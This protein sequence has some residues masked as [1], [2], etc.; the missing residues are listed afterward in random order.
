MAHGGQELGFRL[1]GLLGFNQGEAAVFLGLL[2]FRNVRDDGKDT[3]VGKAGLVCP[4]PLILTANINRSSGVAVV[5]HPFPDEFLFAAL[6]VLDGLTVHHRSYHIFKG[7]TG[8][9]DVG[10]DLHQ[11]P[12]APVEKDQSVIAVEKRYTDWHVL[13]GLGELLSRHFCLLAFGDVDADGAYLL[14][15][16]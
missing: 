3:A 16:T 5:F 10:H 12:V 1:V 14:D 11:F 4:Q 15:G 13:N 6:G 9:Q 7:N 8:F 2:L